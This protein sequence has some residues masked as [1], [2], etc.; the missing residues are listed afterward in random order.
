MNQYLSR[1]EVSDYWENL[2]KRDVDLF[3]YSL[4]TNNLSTN[5]SFSF[6]N[7]IVKLLMPEEV[8]IGTLEF[9]KKYCELD[10]SRSKSESKSDYL[11]IHSVMIRDLIRNLNSNSFC[12]ILDLDAFP[13]S[14]YAIKLTFVLAMLKGINGNIQRTNCIDNGK[15]LFIGPSYICFNTDVMQNL[16][17]SAWIANERSDV[18]EEITWVKPDLIDQNLF[19]PIKTLSK[20]IWALEGK[21]KVYGLGT[22]FGYNNLPVNYHHFY[23]RNFI[24]RL[25]FF[26]ISFI[27]YIKIKLAINKNKKINLKNKI[28]SLISETKF[29]IKYILGKVSQ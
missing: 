25:H 23:S 6:R 16:N 15:H 11:S 17:E 21:K 12:L 28:K 18:S 20:P 24:A 29:S 10:S 22:T 3:V 1:Q 8:K 19:R 26:S 9:N 13:L 5:W 14:K 7:K 2:I 27:K 4:S